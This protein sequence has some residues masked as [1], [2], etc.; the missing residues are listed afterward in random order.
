MNNPLINNPLYKQ[1]RTWQLILA[2]LERIT[3]PDMHITIASPDLVTAQRTYHICLVLSDYEQV[4]V[5]TLD[6]DPVITYKNG[7]QLTFT[8]PY[9]VFYD[10]E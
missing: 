7:S 4:H 8:T 5:A 6:P 3:T 9:E 1:D 10:Q 2:V